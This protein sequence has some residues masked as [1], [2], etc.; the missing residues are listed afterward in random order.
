MTPAAPQPR[1]G[2][3]GR[4]QGSASLE[5]AITAVAVLAVI[6]TAIQAANY[7]WARS[8]A[9][10]AAQEGADAQRAYN[11][12]PGS[13]QARAEAFIAS[14]GDTLSDTTVTITSDGQQVQA[15]V[16]GQ[17]LSIIPGFCSRVIIRATV[18]GTVERITS[19]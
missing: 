19:P 7:F 5:F 11:A 10:A 18:Y 2:Q 8:V 6:F 16:S 3:P 17:C 9:I 15:I 13:G 12:A 14:A 4:D 1:R